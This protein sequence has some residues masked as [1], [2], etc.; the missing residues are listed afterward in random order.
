M[1]TIIIIMATLLLVL[2]PR[3]GSHIIKIPFN[4][5]EADAEKCSLGERMYS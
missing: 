4:S 2:A 1:S 3:L 5:E